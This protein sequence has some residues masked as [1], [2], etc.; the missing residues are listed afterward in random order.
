MKL[1]HSAFRRKLAAMKNLGG[2]DLQAVLLYF[3]GLNVFVEDVHAR[4]EHTLLFPVLR[5]LVFSCARQPREILNTLDRLESDHLMLSK[6]G[7]TILGNGVSLGRE[8]VMQ[9]LNLYSRILVEHNQSEE[10]LVSE[11]V[12]DCGVERLRQLLHE[13]SKKSPPPWEAIGWRNYEV[14]MSEA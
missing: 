12:A 1:E 6:L 3:K 10:E 9:R 2:T 11:V 5:E 14:F 13:K 4:T 8:T 7:S